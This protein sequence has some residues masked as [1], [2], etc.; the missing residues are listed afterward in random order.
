MGDKSR[1]MALALA[2][3]L[4]VSPL[5]GCGGSSSGEAAPAEAGQAEGTGVANPFVDCESAYDAAQLAGFDVTFPESVP[6]YTE[7]TYQAI[8]GELVQCLYSEGES[9]V[10]VR[11]GVDDGSGDLSGNYNE[12]AE[13]STASI[14]DVE[15]TERGE[16]GLVFVAT[17][18]RDGYAFAIDADEGLDPET[19]EQ[20]VAAIL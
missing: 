10:L 2:A 18:A 1:L 15:V 12:Y 17:W 13:T 4:A 5:V 14:G 8:E 6:G 11:K 16:N 3:A 9:R 7:R 19:V 20:L